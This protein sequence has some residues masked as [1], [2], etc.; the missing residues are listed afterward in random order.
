MNQLL[1]LIC[2]NEHFILYSPVGQTRNNKMGLVPEHQEANDL[3]FDF[4]IRNKVTN[5]KWVKSQV[6][7]T[8]P[9]E[10]PT[11]VVELEEILRRFRCSF[12]NRV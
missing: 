8:D 10:F 1:I 3:I 4:F 2:H 6:Y 5:M 12:V 7:G 9:V 11:F